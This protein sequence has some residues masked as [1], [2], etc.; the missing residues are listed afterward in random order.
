MRTVCS[1]LKFLIRFKDLLADID[2]SLCL[3]SGGSRISRRGGRGPRT[4]GRGPPR[5]LRFKN[6]A[7]QN[8]RILTRR[9][10]RAPGAPPPRSAN[11]LNPHIAFGTEMLMGF[12]VFFSAVTF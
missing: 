4:G 8:E 6:F 1:E 3:Y 11:A 12:E 2:F 10:G 5:W 7:C 9:G